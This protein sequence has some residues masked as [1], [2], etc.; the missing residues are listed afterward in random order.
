MKTAL[1]ISP[2][3]DDAVFSCAGM[4]HRLAGEGWQV[5]VATV[6]TEGGDEHAQRRVEDQEAAKLLDFEVSHLGFKDAPFREPGYLTLRDLLFGWQAEDAATICAVA[7]ALL[8]LRVQRAPSRVFVPMG[9]G[10][11]VDHRIVHEAALA[12]G[13]GREVML[14]EERPYVYACGAVE[15]RLGKALTSEEN[16]HY[17]A[18]WRGLPFV[19]MHL[20]PGDEAEL[21]ERLLLQDIREAGVRCVDLS[22]AGV[23]EVVEMNAAE[24]TLCHEAA[25]CYPSQYEAFCGGEAQHALLDA[26]HAEDAGSLAPRCERYWTMICPA[27]PAP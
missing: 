27:T 19:K 23:A 15:R 12:V 26:R 16:E 4:M 2:H 8:A 5:L 20:P 22:Q 3:L 10:T 18:A 6:F 21:C 1:F 11:H 24:V 25:R 14:Y 13:W 7:D 9:A 17:L